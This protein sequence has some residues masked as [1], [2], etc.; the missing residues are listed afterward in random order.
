MIVPSM[1]SEELSKEVFQDYKSVLMK[2]KYLIPSLRR[3]AIKSKNK[4]YHQ[5]F[6]YKTQ[7]RN[8]WLICV[9]YYPIEPTFVVIVYYLDDKGFNAIMV[10]ADKKNLNHFTSHFLDRFNERFLKQENI[11]K[12]ELLK[13]FI[14]PNS[15][16]S[17]QFIPDLDNYRNRFFCRFK[18]GIGLGYTEQVNYSNEINHFK[19]FISNE[20]IFDSQENSFQVTSEGFKKYWDEMFKHTGKDAF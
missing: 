2:A 6:D 17:L 11:S 20:M 9:H 8:D 14:T 4:N 16:G 19:T 5:I 13:R 7:S 12:L 15:I 3:K 1:N 18:E 10:N